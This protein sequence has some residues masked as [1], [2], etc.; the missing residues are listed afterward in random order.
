MPL[1]TSLAVMSNLHFC[2][3]ISAL[4]TEKKKIP[5]TVKPD[6]ERIICQSLTHTENPLKPRRHSSP[7]HYRSVVTQLTYGFNMK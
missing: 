5:K 4:E 3:Y 6:D 1:Q 7:I 2:L